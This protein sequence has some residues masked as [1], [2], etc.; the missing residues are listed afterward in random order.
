[1]NIIL[2]ILQ[3]LL[4]FVFASHGWMLVS[5]P[6]ELLEIM[7]E[8]MGVGF[9]LFLGVSELAGAAGLILPAAIRVLPRLTPI[10]AGCLAFVVASATVVHLFR[11][12]FSS[13]MMTVALCLI[14][15]FVAY[16]RLR[17]RPIAPRGQG[18]TVEPVAA[19]ELA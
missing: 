1:M 6:P 11:G 14:A 10:A 9:R 3:I 8:Q 13:A 17:I 7:N 15:A 12:E 4:A 19:Q 5:P 16:A 2:W 18:S